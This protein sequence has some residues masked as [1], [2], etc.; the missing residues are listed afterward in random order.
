M[1][2][3]LTSVNIRVRLC[4]QLVFPCSV[5]KATQHF[6]LHTSDS[7]IFSIEKKTK[8]SL[9]RENFSPTRLCS[10][11]LKFW[12]DSFSFPRQKVRL[13]K[14]KGENQNQI[15]WC[16]QCTLTLQR[17]RKSW[18]QYH[19]ISTIFERIKNEEMYL[20]VLFLVS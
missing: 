8:K 5:H 4:W 12:L 18:H 14:E 1:M 19:P 15:D 16:S 9:Q 10:V 20:L 7:S 13:R 6:S 17:L 3:I 2:N 11:V